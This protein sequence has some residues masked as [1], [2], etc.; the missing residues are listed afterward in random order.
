[1]LSREKILLLLFFVAYLVYHFYTL[2]ISPLPWFDET[3]FVSISKSFAETGKFVAE[4]SKEMGRKEERFTYGPVFFLLQ[5]M[6]YKIFGFSIIS[7]R[8]ISL[9]FGFLTVIM[10][11]IISRRFNS[12][13]KV[14]IL[15]IVLFL[16]DPFLNM[17]LHEGRMDLVAIFFMLVSIH[18]LFK[19]IDTE[20]YK[21]YF[22]S[23]LSSSV[24]LLT[25]PRVAFIYI[26]LGLILLFS[27]EGKSLKQSLLK[28][29][30]WIAPIIFL[31]TAWVFYAFGGFIELYLYYKNLSGHFLGG[32]LYIP[33]HEKLLIAMTALAV[34][35][36]IVQKGLLYF[37]KMVIMALLSIGLFYL[38][39]RD[40][41]PYSTLVLPFYYFL[42]VQGIIESKLSFKNYSLYPLLLIFIFNISFFAVKSVQ[43]LAEAEIKDSKLAD[44]FIKDN[45]AVGSKVIGDAQFYY[46]VIKAGSEY[47]LYDQYFSD[48]QRERL[49][50]E[51]FDYDY[52]IVSERA[53]EMQAAKVAVFLKNGQFKKVATLK[54]PESELAKRIGSLGIVSTTDRHGYNATI[55]VR[56]KDYDTQLALRK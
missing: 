40:Y 2:V 44:Q 16:L 50:R 51:E 31:Y 54:V 39:V 38:I 45:I 17:V 47:R 13:P 41:G 14:F 46:S 36:G 56:I 3:Y 8:W 23:G 26:A 48:E 12:S 5:A 7:F 30:L 25:T 18:L 10:T 29:A 55:L 37:N 27:L 49:L 24:A 20:R 9:V 19:G 22:F 6:S 1:M 34:I 53:E 11:A 43:V 35:I 33:K 52:F 21:L 32:S 28:I 4:V 15:L 42:L